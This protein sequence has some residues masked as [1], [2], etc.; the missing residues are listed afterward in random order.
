MTFT[1]KTDAPPLPEYAPGAL[2]VGDSRVL[3]DLVNRA[4][5]NGTTSD[6]IMQHNAALTPPPANSVVALASSKRIRGTPGPTRE[7]G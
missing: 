4:F 7:E 2:H 5:Q 3:L 6:A 1:V